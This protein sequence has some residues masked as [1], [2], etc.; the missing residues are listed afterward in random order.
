MSKDRYF[1]SRYTD[2]PTSGLDK[3]VT[4][5]RQYKIQFTVDRWGVTIY[6]PLIPMGLYQLIQVNA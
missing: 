2:Y 1:I 4:A 6:V 3:N 5:Q